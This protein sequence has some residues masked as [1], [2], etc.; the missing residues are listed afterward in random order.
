MWMRMKHPDIADSQLFRRLVVKRP[1]CCGPRGL[2][3]DRFS[4]QLRARNEMEYCDL[5][6][7]AQTLKLSLE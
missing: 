1:F 4:E 5:S 6:A 7:R 3:G 2:R